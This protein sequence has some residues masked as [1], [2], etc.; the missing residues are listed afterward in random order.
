MTTLVKAKYLSVALIAG[1]LSIAAWA[2][3]AT[4]ENAVRVSEAW[5]E[6]LGLLAYWLQ[7]RLGHE[8]T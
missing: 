6:W 1:C 4:A 3:S 2:N 8:A 5:H 7:G